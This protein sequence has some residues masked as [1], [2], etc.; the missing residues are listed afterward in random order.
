MNDGLI[1]TDKWTG[2]EGANTDGIPVMVRYRQNLQSFIDTG[3]YNTKVN[4]TWSYDTDEAALMP[5]PGEADVMDNVEE[6]LLL[7]LE[8]D[9]QAILVAVETGQGT[10]R[11][12]WYTA[13]GEEMEKRMSDVLERFETLP[14]DYTKTEDPNWNGYFDFITDFGGAG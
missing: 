1:L 3:L 6:A 13:D 4:M 12:T 9:R 5:N 10:K 14:L 2:A 11:W 7:A 8:G